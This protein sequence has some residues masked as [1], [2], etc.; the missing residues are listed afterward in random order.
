VRLREQA[1]GREELVERESRSGRH[2]M[3]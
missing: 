3:G 1:A 2:G